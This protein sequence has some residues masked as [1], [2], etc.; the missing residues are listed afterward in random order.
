MTELMLFIAGLLAGAVNSLAGGGSFIAFPA[1]LFAGVPPVMANASN[2]FAAMPGYV[3][4]TFGYW[5]AMRPYRDRLIAYTIVAA[6]FGYM[7]AELLLVV[8]D[9][10]FRKVVPWLMLFAVALFAFG[11]QFNAAVKRLGGERRGAR[12]LGLVA[13]WG[14]LGLVCLYGGFFNA[15]LGILLL[16]FLATA[17]MSDIHAMNGLKLWIS[18]VVALIAVVRFAFD[19]AIDWYHGSIT[20]VGVVIGGYVAARLAVYIPTKAIKMGVIIYGV[21]MTAY[22]FYAAYA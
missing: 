12:V 16:A 2:T 14:F 7:G 11:N 1:L 18:S 20:L 15:G 19:G 22:F 6:I 13:L 3:S 10:Q 8:S 21:F 5:G 17:G 9:D 4:G